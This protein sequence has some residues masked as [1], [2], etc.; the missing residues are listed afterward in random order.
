MCEP[1]IPIIPS[2]PASET[3]RAIAP[4]D[5]PAIGAPMTGVVRSNQRVSGVLI[6]GS[7]C[8][9]PRARGYRADR[10]RSGRRGD[11]GE[12]PAGV[13]VGLGLPAARVGD[14]ADGR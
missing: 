2:P 1:L 6:T 9:P 14:A 10:R 5:T 13:D 3:A 8:R 12:R 11:L 4:P 7:S